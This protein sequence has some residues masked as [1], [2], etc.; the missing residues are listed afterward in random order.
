MNRKVFL[1]LKK[2]SIYKANIQKSHVHG[3]RVIWVGHGLRIGRVIGVDGG[4]ACV[5]G[6]PG[7]VLVPRTYTW[8]PV[9][10]LLYFHQ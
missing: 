2:I 10:K 3:Q 7:H 4:P 8:V 5:H 1:S 9:I 6:R